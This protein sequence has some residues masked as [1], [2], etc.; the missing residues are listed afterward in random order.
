MKSNRPKHD[1]NNN[2]HESELEKKLHKEL[3]EYVF[4]FF[5][6]ERFEKCCKSK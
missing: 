1:I 2:K 4:S 5:Q 6:P 3:Q